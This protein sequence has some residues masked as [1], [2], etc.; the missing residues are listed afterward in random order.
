MRLPLP[1]AILLPAV[2]LLAS[3]PVAL[4]ESLFDL[5]FSEHGL[6]ESLTVA[7]WVLAGAMFTAAAM[8]RGGA[9]AWLAAPLCFAA[10]LREADVHQAMTGISILKLRFYSS[11]VIEPWEKLAA[12]G[13]LLPLLTA[14]AVLLGL[15]LRRWRCDGLRNAEMRMM[16]GAIGLLVSSK[17]VDRLPAVLREWSGMETAAVVVHSMQAVEEGIELLLPVLFLASYA[18]ANPGRLPQRTAPRGAA[19]ASAAL[20]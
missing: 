1:G 20:I 16:C 2:L 6:V 10:A 5:A 17:V 9:V 7:L 12:V 8:V 3:A 14:A 18:L 11:D 4:P 19:R 15:F 13:V